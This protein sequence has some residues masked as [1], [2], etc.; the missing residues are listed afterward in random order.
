MAPP[1]DSTVDVDKPVK[2]PSA[3]PTAAQPPSLPPSSSEAARDTSLGKRPRE[4]FGAA[5]DGGSASGAA[6]AASVTSK[7]QQVE[8]T[9]KVSSIKSKLSKPKPANV[10][11]SGGERVRKAGLTRDELLSDQERH[12]AIQ[13]AK[14]K[15]VPHYRKV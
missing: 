6:A 9:A 10:G 5:G 8:T 11:S 2:L 13:E 7:L 15:A 12:R 3:Q 14:G 1:S 4:W